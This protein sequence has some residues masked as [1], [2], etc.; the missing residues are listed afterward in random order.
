MRS[1]LRYAAKRLLF[2]PPMI[3]LIIVINFVVLQL[4]PGDVAD[5]LAGLSGAGTPEYMA[6]LRRDFGLDQPVIVQLWRYIW[7]VVNLNLGYSFWYNLPVATLI[8]KYLPA[9]LMLMLVSIGIAIGSGIFL[10]ATSARFVNRPADG[11]IT[12]FALLCYATPTFWI[13]LMMIVV[14]SLKLSWF[15]TGG[16]ITIGADLTG[17]KYVIDLIHHA[18]L[19]G[20]ALSLFYVAIYTR[21]MRAS[22][23]EVYGQDFVRTAFAKGLTDNQVAFRHVLRNALFPIVTMGGMQIGYTLGG[24]VLVETV[25]GWP[26]LG[27]VASEAILQR[28]YN[29]LMGILIIGSVLVLI[30]NILVDLIYGFLD[31]RIELR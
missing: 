4:T 18:V 13:G 9:T 20:I 16:M 21:L 10:G 27:R 5:V 28:D 30:M 26:G 1:V 15:P 2:V 24:S 23:L 17:W 29:L 6:S 11:I 31:P 3:L 25:F 19:P 22:M 12:V 14:F 8:W 7:N